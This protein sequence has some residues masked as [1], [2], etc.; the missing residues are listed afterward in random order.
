MYLNND[1][2][3]FVS[4]ENELR[5]LLY[6]TTAICIIKFNKRLRKL[7]SSKVVKFSLEYIFFFKG[8]FY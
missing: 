6:Y 8:Y 2:I 3:A 4:H 1:K 5:N 7:C